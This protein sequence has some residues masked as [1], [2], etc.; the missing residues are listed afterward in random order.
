MFE[1]KEKFVSKRILFSEEALSQENA[2]FSQ[3]IFLCLI[4]NK[5]WHLFWPSVLF[6]FR[7][8]IV[9]GIRGCPALS[10]CS[11]FTGPR[12]TGRRC[13]SGKG[14]SPVYTNV[15]RHLRMDDITWGC[16]TLRKNMIIK[17]QS[18]VNRGKFCITFAS[19]TFK[20]FINMKDCV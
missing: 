19:S 1:A 10:T 13:S 16:V 5:T 7:E 3:N 14:L 2:D 18:L 20:A 4:V 8:V 11:T 6:F 9:I 12:R 17:F 15:W